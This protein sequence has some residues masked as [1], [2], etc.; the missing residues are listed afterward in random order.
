MERERG[1]G[2]EGGRERARERQTIETNPLG[3]D[4]SLR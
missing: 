1:E 2:K 3:G 4:P